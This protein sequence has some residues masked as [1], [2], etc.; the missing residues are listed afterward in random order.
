MQ[1]WFPIVGMMVVWVQGLP[2]MGQV[3]VGTPKA[4]SI[5]VAFHGDLTYRVEQIDEEGKADRKRD[6]LRARV[7][8]DA[9]LPNDLR[10]GMEI[11][12]GG[13]SPVSAYQTLGEG[14][15][16]K[17]IRFNLAYMEWKGVEGVCLTGGKMKNPFAGAGELIWDGD[18]TPEG[19]AVQA[20][21]R[22]GSAQGIINAGS[23]WLQERAEGDDLN[24]SQ[25]QLGV[26]LALPSASTLL[27]GC[28]VCVF[29]NMEGQD[30]LDWENKNNVYG[31]STKPGAVAGLVTNKVYAEGFTVCEGFGRLGLGGL[32][33]PAELTI[34]YIVNTEAA[35]HDMG[36]L[37]GGVVGKTE[38]GNL[39]L[40]YNYRELQKDATPGFLADSDIWGGGTDG[41]GH[42]VSVRYALSRHAQLGVNYCVAE[43]P[44]SDETR[45][46]DV[47]RYQFEVGVKF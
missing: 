41:R 35:D 1:R 6:R 14:V 32:P 12:T 43:K 47:V 19:V 23:F 4:D 24:V 8:A 9:S 16:R 37:V 30:V 17:D 26:K 5:P 44:V 33:V 22:V 18:V 27:V 25:G 40:A 3:A 28:G 34:Q 10:V 38:P 7:G 13:S 21:R 29:D 36:Y 20:N 15:S 2:V 39:Q 31:N 42:K 46:H 45:T 11:S